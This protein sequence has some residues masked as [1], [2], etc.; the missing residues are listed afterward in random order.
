MYLYEERKKMI[1][2]IKKN[3]KFIKVDVNEKECKNKTCFVPGK[4][5]HYSSAGY[6]GCSHWTDK[7][8]SCLTRDNH[9][10]PEKECN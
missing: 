10:C 2:K 4:Y 3:N 7:N 9:G 6:S 8:Y 5:T 1:I